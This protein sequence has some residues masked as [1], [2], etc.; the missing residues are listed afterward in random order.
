MYS[1]TKF[2]EAANQSAA[3]VNR[4]VIEITQ[5]NFNLGFDLAKSL[6]GGARNPSQIVRLQRNFWRKQF[7][8]LTAQAEE[9]RNRLFGFSAAKP[10]TLEASDETTKKS[11]TRLL[12][13]HNQTE[14]GPAR[15][16]QKPGARSPKTPP[17]TRRTAGS[18]STPLDK[19]QPEIQ[20]K[21]TP[22]DK[23]KRIQ[24]SP[25]PDPVAE[26]A[27]AARTKVKARPS[28]GAAPQSIPT[29]IK[30]GILDGNAVR[31]TNLEAWCLV[32]GTWRSIAP[33]EVLS[34]AAVIREARFNQ[35]FPQVPLLPKKAFQSHRR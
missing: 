1:I 6:A 9:V 8:E 11:P 18:G 30:F 33:G 17:L 5:R 25:G 3:T 31:F 13:G 35:L 20:K 16:E 10:N 15:L 2:L 22:T 24:K 19:K 14:Q 4:K 23:P 28:S 29:D 7:N 12:K 27:K 21:G 32:D 26:K 34:N